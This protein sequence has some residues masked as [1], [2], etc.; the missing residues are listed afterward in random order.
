M[1]LICCPECRKRISE[2]ADSCPKC[3]YQLTP[4]IISE[5]RKK[6]RRALKTLGMLTAFFILAIFLAIFV[7]AISETPD[8][9]TKGKNLLSF[10]KQLV[11][12][13]LDNPKP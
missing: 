5:I 1:A 6:N 7:A 4:E 10:R 2:T 11:C 13:H 9:A 12:F 3:G 8:A